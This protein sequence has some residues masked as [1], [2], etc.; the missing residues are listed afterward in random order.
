MEE[1]QPL[2]IGEIAPAKHRGRMIALDNMSVTF[3]QLIS[4]ALGAALTGPAHG[5]RWMVAIGGVPPI[6]L[7]TLLPMCPESPRQLLFHRKRDETVKVITLIY[8][9]ATPAQVQEKV[10]GI[11]REIEAEMNALEGKSLWWQFKQL[12]TVGTNLRPLITACAI[13]A[14]KSLFRIQFTFVQRQY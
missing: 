14:S 13:M 5:W 8:P 10:D 12:H 3:G 6:V 7:C 4:Y 1:F 11:N 9:Q 2:Y